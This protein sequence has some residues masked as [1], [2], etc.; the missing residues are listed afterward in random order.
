MAKAIP[1]ISSAVSPFMRRAV[2]NAPNWAG[3]A[4]PSMMT[5]IASAASPIERSLPSTTACIARLMSAIGPGLFHIEKVLQQLL[6][7]RRH[8][9]FRMELHA[10]YRVLAV[11][12]AHDDAVVGARRDFQ[13]F[14]Q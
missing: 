3:V 4:S 5:P 9:R 8:N 7:R 10:L 11:P 2:T 1:A 14:R 13:L 6:A 12:D